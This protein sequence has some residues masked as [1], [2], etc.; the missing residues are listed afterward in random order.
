MANSLKGVVPGQSGD[1]APGQ[2]K[3]KVNAGAKAAEGMHKVPMDVVPEQE[4]DELGGPTPT[5]D[6]E[7]AQTLHPEKGVEAGQG[8]NRV[9]KGSK[10]AEKMEKLDPSVARQLRAEEIDAEA[11]EEMN[12]L[13]EQED[14]LSA[15]FKLQ[16]RTIFEA[17]LQQKLEL[18]VERLEEEFASRFDEEIQDITEKVES[19]L[20][21][22]T[23][24]WLEENRIA[25][26]EGV[27]NEL[28]ESFMQGLKGLF[29]AHYVSLP[30]EKYDIFESMVTKLDEME[31]KLNEQISTNVMLHEQLNEYRREFAL[32]EAQRGLTEAQKDKLASLA[33]SV[34]FESE[35]TF[36]RKLDILKENFLQTREGQ[37]LVEDSPVEGAG[38]EY[39]DSMS[40]Y[41]RALGARL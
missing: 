30:E 23:V 29:E 11:R 31:E 33:E 32:H 37:Y 27:K 15:E 21:Y 26:E 7:A 36:I 39:T 20:D 28:N 25:V 12:Q 17:A 41:I 34:E 14:G 40:H 3:S 24:Q 2:S 22:S 6:S 9:T 16:A 38:V 35:D 5:D 13:L 10:A 1:K 18:E 19:F 8:G 4:I